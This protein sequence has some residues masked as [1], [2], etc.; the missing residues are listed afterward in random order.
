MAVRSL[1]LFVSSS[2]SIALLFP[3]PPRQ[4]TIIPAH[5]LPPFISRSRHSLPT[6]HKKPL[7]PSQS[8]PYDRLRPSLSQPETL[9]QKIGK[10]IRRPGAP[11]KARVYSDINVIRPKDYWDYESLTVQWGFVSFL[12]SFTPI[13]FTYTYVCVRVCVCVFN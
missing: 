4:I 9:A 2:A 6:K 1:K 10:S 5:F 13:Y 11:S 7:P 3:L 12:S 8:P